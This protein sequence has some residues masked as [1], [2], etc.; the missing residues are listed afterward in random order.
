VLTEAIQEQQ[1][2]LERKNEEIVSI[3]KD[4]SNLQQQ[5]TDL[6]KLVEAS[7]H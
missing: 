7:A 1:K 4:F 2:Q 5:F 3:R 6:K